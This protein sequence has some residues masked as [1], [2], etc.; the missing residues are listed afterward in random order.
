VNWI[1]ITSDNS[2]SGNGTVTYTVASKAAG[3]ARKGTIN[4]SG[5][6]FTV[7]QK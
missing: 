2:G 5:Q 4:V 6:V 7:K 1:T 3:P